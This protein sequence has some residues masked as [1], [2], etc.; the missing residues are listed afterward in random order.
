MAKKPEALRVNIV[1][2]QRYENK[3]RALVLKMVNSTNKEIKTIFHGKTAKIYF[4][5]AQDAKKEKGLSLKAKIALAA[6]FLKF[7]RMFN[8]LGRKYAVNMVADTDKYASS[9][10]KSSLK[11]LLNENV[12]TTPTTP[13]GA[14]RIQSLINENQLLIVS[15]A[16]YY[17]TQATGYVMR[18][19]SSGVP[20]NIESDLKKQEGITLRRATNI[21]VDQTQKAMQSIGMQK[22]IDQDINLFEWVYT[23]RSKEQRKTHV[24]MNGTIHSF[25]NPPIVNGDNP[26]ESPRYGLPGSEPNCKCIMRPVLRRKRDAASQR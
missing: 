11:T 20:Q 6:L 2:Q 26:G 24:K 19:I 25:D 22:L 9:V 8:K 7:K 21:A 3:L 18:A 16:T 17:F 5:Y 14:Q 10:V 13:T 4:I 23:F 12:N 1:I 15:L